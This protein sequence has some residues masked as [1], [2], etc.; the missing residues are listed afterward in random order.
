[1]SKNPM[2]LIKSPDILSKQEIEELLPKLDDIITWAK[3]VQEYALNQ[4]L[5]GTKYDGFKVVE[6]RAIRKFTNET[7][8][9]NALIGEGYEEAV[10]YER[11]MLSLSQIEKLVGKKTFNAVCSPYVEIPQGKPT[12][13]PENDKRPEF[14]PASP[15]DDFDEEDFE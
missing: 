14:T 2:D 1:M 12:L 10:L 6:G 7:K 5:A 9:A 4:A 3:Q 8:V 15:K 13:V 11:R